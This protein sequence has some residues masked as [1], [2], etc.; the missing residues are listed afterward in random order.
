MTKFIQLML[1]KKLLL[2]SLLIIIIIIYNTY[3]DNDSIS[4]HLPCL[5]NLKEY[6]DQ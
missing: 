5:M 3:N 1:L 6:E 4:F 2:S